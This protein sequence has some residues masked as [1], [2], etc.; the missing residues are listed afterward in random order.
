M[1][2]W[3]VVDLDDVYEPCSQKGFD[4]VGARRNVDA[5]FSE[6]QKVFSFGLDFGLRLAINALDLAVDRDA[7]FPTTFWS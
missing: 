6:L 3:R 1:R 2:P 7:A 4:R 5:S